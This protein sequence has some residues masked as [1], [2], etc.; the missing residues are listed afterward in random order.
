MQYYGKPF[1]NFT[2]YFTRGDLGGPAICLTTNFY[3]REG[4]L[5]ITQQIEKSEHV[6]HTYI[7]LGYKIITP[8][9][10]RKLADLLETRIAQAEEKAKIE[11]PKEDFDEGDFAKMVKELIEE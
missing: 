2:F 7:D 10:L 9:T 1:E 8:N 11:P 3:R 4:S 6:Y 5:A